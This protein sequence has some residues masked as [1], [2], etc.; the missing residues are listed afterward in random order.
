M[1]TRLGISNVFAYGQRNPLTSM[2]SSRTVS[3]VFANL[4][5][6]V[7]DFA[8]LEGMIRQMARRY[9]GQAIEVFSQSRLPVDEDRFRVFREGVD[10]PFTYK[11]PLTNLSVSS[12][13]GLLGRV[14]RKLLG[15]AWVQGRQVRWAA[16]EL[17]AVVDES[18]LG[19][20]EAVFFPGGALWS[21]GELAV[22]LF[23]LLQALVGRGVAVYTFPFSVDRSVL[24]KNKVA[25]L[26][27]YFSWL[28]GPILVRDGG[29]GDTLG[30]AGVNSSLMPDVAFSL[31]H[32]DRPKPAERSRPRVGLAI[33]GSREPNRAM[34]EGVLKSLRAGGVDP[35]LV[36]T[37]L[38]EDG[39][40]LES[41]AAALDLP[42]LQPLGWR[43]AVRE[44]QALDL[45]LCNRLHG[46]VFAILGG[47]PII[48][49][50]NREKVAGLAR[51]AGLS[52]KVERLEQVTADAVKEWVREAEE[53]VIEMTRYRSAA[54][55]AWDD[56]TLASESP[57]GKDVA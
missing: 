43:D 12:S 47:T 25:D 32:R 52:R 57:F 2:S 10:V 45:L 24:R 50:V 11:G 17:E 23:G 44:F 13:S 7:G 49:M 22:N 33:A 54:Q 40:I 28:S 8:I 21:G 34:F 1:L 36:T 56:I 55:K 41:M 19:G 39:E 15:A 3:I 37:C 48:P 30:L 53:V 26:R 46:L 38:P 27:R 5:G 31:P 18:G 16:G 4:K 29:S 35:V 14:Q 20:H 6:N 9:P 51:D 42:L